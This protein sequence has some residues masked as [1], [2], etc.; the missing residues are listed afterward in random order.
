MI[1]TSFLIYP[2]F[3]EKVKD[4]TKDRHMPVILR[5]NNRSYMQKMKSLKAIQ[6]IK[7]ASILC[8]KIHQL[9]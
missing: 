7:L 4:K 8:I 5:E 9:T 6:L 1:I 2:L 3:S